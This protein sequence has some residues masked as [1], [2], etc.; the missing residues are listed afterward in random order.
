MKL[1]ELKIV[2][3]SYSQTQVGSYVLVM[4]EKK[5]KKKLPIIINQD[6]AQYIALKLESVKVKRPLTFDLFKNLTDRLGAD[7]YQ[8]HITNIL[9]G[10]FY[11]K[12]IFHNMIEEFEIESSISDAV[13]LS[14]SYKCPVFC[15]KEVL[16]IAGILMDDDGSMSEEQHEDNHKKRDY[17]S[18]ISI[19]NLEK[20]LD[21]AIENEEYEIA[22]QLRDRIV[23]LKEKSK[24]R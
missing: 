3:L 24:S 5:G 21:K 15:S 7:L 8:I 2:G 13:C 22:S 20:M 14:V 19:E 17:S 12:L 16:D 6:T 1:K 18:I 4:S 11:V 9:E 10:V 23:E